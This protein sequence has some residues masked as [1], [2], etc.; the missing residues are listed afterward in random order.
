MDRKAEIM[1]RFG[2][3]LD[4][5]T[6]ELLARHEEVRFSKISEINPGRVNVR[7][8]ITG[9]GDP[10]SGNEI[11][12]SDETGRIKVFVSREIYMKADIG[13]EIE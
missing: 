10:E 6:A 13:K 12:I 4:E 3:L 2:D 11:Y 1:D 7:G 5:E 9:I 8:T